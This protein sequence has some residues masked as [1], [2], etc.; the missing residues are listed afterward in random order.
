VNTCTESAA[1]PGSRRELGEAF[2]QQLQHDRQVAQVHDAE[3][4]PR[5][6]S[7]G[8]QKKQ[9]GRQQQGEQ[10]RNPARPRRRQR[11]G[12]DQQQAE[13]LDGLVQRRMAQD[14]DL[15]DAL[16]ELGQGAF[17]HDQK[18]HAEQADGHGDPE[19][20]NARRSSIRCLAA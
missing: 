2:E 10:Q 19:P 20:G 9:P 16:H 4:E 5:N 6:A 13:Q 8:A 15:E 7:C 1:D 3:V 18:G 17:Q 11:S 14:V 12:D